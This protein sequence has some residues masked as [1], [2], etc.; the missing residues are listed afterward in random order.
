M[1]RRTTT[2]PGG[3][4]ANTT[5]F[6][7]VLINIVV[8]VQGF[9]NSGKQ[10]N[11]PVSDRECDPE[12]KALACRPDAGEF[13]STLACQYAGIP[14]LIY[15]FEPD[16]N[17]DKRISE[18]NNCTGARLDI[19]FTET[20]DKMA[21]EVVND[22][23]AGGAGI[24]DAYI[25][26]LPW[27]IPVADKMQDLSNLITQNI[28]D[29]KWSDINENSR[30][31]VTFNESVRALP[32]DTDYVAIGYRQDVYDK[33]N[34]QPPN[35]IE[36]MAEQSEFLYGLDHNDDGVADWGFCLSGQANYFFAFVASVF[37][38][39]FQM[40]KEEDVVNMFFNTTNFEQIIG[41]NEGFRYVVQIYERIL[42]TSNCV[43]QIR[44]GERCDRRPA[45]KTGRCAAVISLPG[46][47]DRM[48]LPESS[49][50]TLSPRRYADTL[51]NA[52]SVGETG[53]IVWTP[54]LNT[55]TPNCWGRRARFPGS[56]R[57]WNAVTKTLV[58]CTPILCP[59]GESIDGTIIN[60]APFFAE[61]GEVY[62]IRAGVAGLKQNM[63]WNFFTWLSQLPPVELPL[64]GVYRQSQIDSESDDIGGDN[65]PAT[66]RDDLRSVLN[67]YFNSNNAAQDMLI[68]GYAGYMGSLETVL[69]ADYL[70]KKSYLLSPPPSEEKWDIYFKEFTDHLTTAWDAVTKH[71]D[72]GGELKQLTRFRSALDLPFLTEESLCNLQVQLGNTT[73][74]G[75]DCD[76]IVAFVCT[77]EKYGYSA[78]ECLDNNKRHI[79]YYTEYPL[80]T[81][82]AVPDPALE[83][84]SCSWVPVSSRYGWIV[85]TI[86]LMGALVNIFMLVL[87]HRYK[88]HPFIRA[89]QV[90]I[91]QAF[92]GS[93]ALSCL[94]TLCL[95]GRHT[96]GLCIA[97]YWVLL[98]PVTASIA[99]LFIKVYR[100][101]K[102]FESAKF[103]K[104]N[105]RLTDMTLIRQVFLIV[106]VQV[107]I[108][109]ILTFVEKPASTEQISNHKMNPKYCDTALGCFPPTED[110]CVNKVGILPYVGIGYVVLIIIVGCILSY[111]ARDLPDLFCEAKYVM[112]AM[113]QVF[114]IVI[115]VALCLA[116]FNGLESSENAEA[117][118]LIL[119]VGIVFGATN[120]V[121]LILVP[122]FM[123]V[124]S[125]SVE[126]AR[127]QIEEQLIKGTENTRTSKRGPNPFNSL[128]RAHTWDRLNSLSRMNSL[129]QESN[130]ETENVS[131]LKAKVIFL[132]AQLRQLR[133]KY[134]LDPLDS[135]SKEERHGRNDNVILNASPQSSS[136][137]GDNA[138]A[139]GHHRIDIA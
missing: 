120:S 35:T 100:V 66:A 11:D 82:F 44:R 113:Y 123:S 34:L 49:G 137:E 4:L 8:L 3:Q 47:M 53:D 12:Q 40:P 10:C 107:V 52:T 129:G 118:V 81:V 16:E 36:E 25:L 101:Y 6:V 119:T 57:V 54:S 109:L 138:K 61:G 106:G 84:M 20:E 127:V 33:Y 75:S 103:L 41:D 139:H 24:F 15:G 43:E 68:P 30:K 116:V 125:I 91:M 14:A 18:F 55:S 134:D 78:T 32:L 45:F 83:M 136:D 130:S 1:W 17:W 21:T 98:L 31:A 9:V 64:A 111:Q 29:I 133:E 112:M 77:A 73:S 102:I 74:I 115:I 48:I 86:A 58:E 135:E 50:G 46:T 97:E 87:V 110:V 2:T 56:S 26:E 5:F 121:L 79:W 105:I 65:W 124:L 96:T 85:L 114:F 95:L 108:L 60:F 23:G 59:K 104:Q 90:K 72:I 42:R 63:I 38:T 22:A 7:L 39:G 13:L 70:T 51:P 132:E 62:A 67:S 76:A 69:H 27:V 131:Q 71:K 122:K 89:T 88:E 92:I 28:K 99:F 126:E 93:A 117:T 94:G 128:N 80:C 19:F 37:Q